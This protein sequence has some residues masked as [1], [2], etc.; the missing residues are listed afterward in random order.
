[1]VCQLFFPLRP[2][3]KRCHGH[4][5]RSSTCFFFPG[6]GAQYVGMCKS[7]LKEPTVIQLFDDAHKILGYDL[8]NICLNGPAEVLNKTETCQPAVVVSSLAALRY[9]RAKHSQ[10]KFPTKHRSKPCR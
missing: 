8:L 3:F 5:R 2:F 9:H 10:V 1:M 6:Q 4:L 7:F